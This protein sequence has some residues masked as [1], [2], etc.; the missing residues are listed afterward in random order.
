MNWL[1]VI[2]WQWI[3]NT[4]CALKF[5]INMRRNVTRKIRTGDFV[6][7]EE[8]SPSISFVNDSRTTAVY[9]ES[10]LDSV[11]LESSSRNDVVEAVV[12][13]AIDKTK[14][15]RK[16][17]LPTPSSRRLTVR[18]QPEEL[19]LSCKQWHDWDLHCRRASNTPYTCTHVRQGASSAAVH[20]SAVKRWRRRIGMNNR[21]RSASLSWKSRRIPS[22][23]DFLLNLYAAFWSSCLYGSESCETRTFAP[24]SRKKLS[25]WPTL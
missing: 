13:V 8:Q 17:P 15:V 7:S 12:R 23:A 18:C 21:L 10:P 14:S 9:S 20:A 11:I 1:W 25:V 5:K 3:K 19:D 16:L 24:F 4:L 2:L 6:N 22:I